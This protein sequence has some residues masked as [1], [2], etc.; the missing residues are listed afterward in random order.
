MKKEIIAAVLLIACITS[1]LFAG[2]TGV[3]VLG[4]GNLINKTYEFSD[5]TGVKAG[6]GFQVELIQSDIFSIE[7]TVDDNVMEHVE[8][9]KSGSSLTIRAKGNR[10]FRSVTLKAE[11]TMP[12]IRKLELSGG[13]HANFTGFSSSNDLSINI[14]G[15][16][17]LNS[18]GTPGDITVGDANFNLSGGSH[19][20]LSGSAASLDINGSGGSHFNL[21]DFSVSNASIK[22]S[23]GSHATVDVNGTLDADISGGSRVSYVG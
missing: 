2:C 14:S 20:T 10:S 7:I 4:S 19:V 9:N 1:G 21:E 13:A 11:V 15:G 16:S 17:H 5:F 23:G 22:L 3:R 18:L 8:I 6:N 12:D